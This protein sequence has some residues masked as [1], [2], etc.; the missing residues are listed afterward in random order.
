MLISNVGHDVLFTM[1]EINKEQRKQVAAEEVEALFL[2]QLLRAMDNTVCR[3]EDNVLHSSEEDIF[4]DLMYQEVA[5]TVA[6][7]EGIGL[8]DIIMNE[9]QQ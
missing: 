2:N 4:R 9:M 5:R 3:E 1:S 8:K 7:G 6:R